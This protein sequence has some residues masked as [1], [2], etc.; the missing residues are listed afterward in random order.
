MLDVYLT[1]TLGGG[2]RPVDGTAEDWIAGIKVGE[3]VRV[4]PKKDRNPRF[5]NK[6][7]GTLRMVFKNQ[8]KYLSFEGLRAAVTVAA[9]Y[10]DVIQL[11]GDRTTLVPQS[12]AWDKMDDHQF[13][14]L[15]RAAL[16]AIPRLLPQFEGVDLERELHYTET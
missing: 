11:D 5:H 4:Q 7:M 8:E 12:I 13:A 1:K 9:G 16:E 6:F 14:P 2:L 10:V 15:Y 3:I